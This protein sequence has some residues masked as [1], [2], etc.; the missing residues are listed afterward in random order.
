MCTVH[1]PGMV[2]P[3]PGRSG[4][5]RP[6]SGRNTIP[7]GRTDHVVERPRKSTYCA[8]QQ[9]SWL[10]SVA[11]PFDPR[12]AR[13]HTRIRFLRKKH[14]DSLRKTRISPGLYRLCPLAMG[15][16]QAGST[17]WARTGGGNPD[18][19]ARSIRALPELLVQPCRCNAGMCGGPC[20]RPIAEG[21]DGRVPL[22]R[23]DHQDPTSAADLLP[24]QGLASGDLL[25]SGALI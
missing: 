13:C 14:V 19:A 8:E 21:G 5:L 23:G 4:N 3:G 10:R 9:T 18:R 22:P 1:T 11:R 7:K 6:F 15:P 20:R 25:E 2:A 24:R 17:T 12:A 16:T